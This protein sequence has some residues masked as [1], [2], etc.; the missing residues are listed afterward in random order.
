MKK[1]I[2]L[3]VVFIG[4]VAAWYGTREEK[5]VS[6]VV[7]A[8][9]PEINID[10]VERLEVGGTN[11]VTLVKKGD[12]WI[13]ED[14][15]QAAEVGAGGGPVDVAHELADLEEEDVARLVQDATGGELPPE[16]VEE[17]AEEPKGA[18]A[19]EPHV[20]PV[21]YVLPGLAEDPAEAEPLEG[22]H[23]NLI[24]L[25]LAEPGNRVAV[26]PS[27]TEPKVKFY[28]FAYAPP[29][30]SSDLPAAKRRLSERL[31]ALERDLRAL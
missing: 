30:Q 20:L 22:P 15:G 28:M 21:L 2:I 31:A 25:D 29:E 6:D 10:A 27:G 16:A 18:G 7:K 5:I 8:E 26:R 9:I 3:L 24:I 14:G 4:L 11:K 12:G 23:G 17:L 13:I 1:N 19:G